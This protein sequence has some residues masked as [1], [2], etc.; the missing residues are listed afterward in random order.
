MLGS[1]LFNIFISTLDEGIESTVSKFAPGGAGT[2]K[3]CA[4]TQQD[5]NK[6]KS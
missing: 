3:G 5:L 6:L 1:V 4:A 2:L